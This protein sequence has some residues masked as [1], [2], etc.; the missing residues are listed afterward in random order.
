MLCAPS[1]HRADAVY[2][3]PPETGGKSFAHFINE[4]VT[5]H[6]AKIDKT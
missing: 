2:F 3:F 6:R 4:E 1:C 5:K